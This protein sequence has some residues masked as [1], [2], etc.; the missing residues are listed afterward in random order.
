[1]L[2][3]QDMGLTEGRP[4]VAAISDLLHG[5]EAYSWRILYGGMTCLVLEL[6]LPASR[7]SLVSRVRAANFW[8]VYIVITTSFF[9]INAFVAQ[10][11]IRPLLTIDLSGLAR[12]GIVPLQVIGWIVAYALASLVSDFFYYW[13]HRLQHANPSLW[14]F[15]KVHHSLREMSAWNSYHHFTEEIFRIPFVYL[16]LVML[17][18]VSPGTAPILI[19]P[20]I[21]SI[22]V[23]FIH[24][25]T[26]INFGWFRHVAVDNRYHR[27]HHSIEPQHRDKNFGAFSSIWDSLFRTVYFP[28]PN[29]WPDT[30]LCDVNEPKR[31]SEF[32]W[33]PF[34]AV[35][36]SATTTE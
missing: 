4:M 20:A 28:L 26:R 11:G 29:E 18:N 33:Q 3:D 24:S 25:C 36:H 19:I 14:R 21:V 30:G 27:I 17:I 7:F 12:T 16:P 10:L 9:S 31:L 5:I 35:K 23:L 1:M 22:H 32:L 8:L 15:H 6:L 2:S 13:F 34:R